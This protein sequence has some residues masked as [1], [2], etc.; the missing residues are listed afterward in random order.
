MGD[1]TGE[2]L[3]EKYK[4]TGLLGRGGM[5]AVYQGTHLR[6]GRKV[7]VK[8]LD[9]RFLANRSIVQRFGREARSASSIQHP[10]IVEV[11]DLDQLP[12]GAPFLVME[13]LD[14]ETL[15]SFIERKQRLSQSQAV[16]IF[17]QL[18]EA[19]EAAHERGI[20]HRD[21]KPDNIFLLPPSH[22]GKR[23]VKILD[24]GISQKADEVRSH[25]T[26]TGAVLGTPHYMSPEQALGESA[27]DACADVYAAAVVLYECVVGEVPYDAPN[28][29]ALLQAILRA[30]PVRPRDRGAKIEPAF[31]A[32]LLAGMAKEKS[33]R[34]QT[35]AAWRTML[36]DA[37]S[38]A[39][40]RDPRP[41]REETP[42]PF[43][44][45]SLPVA[46][47]PPSEASATSSLLSEP[48]PVWGEFATLGKKAPSPAAVA[49]AAP[50]LPDATVGN[51]TPAERVSVPP[52]PVNSTA[53][54]ELEDF[55]FDPV[56]PALELD[57]SAL[58]VP[59]R[60][61]VGQAPA[62]RGRSYGGTLQAVNPSSTTG[63]HA[64]QAPTGS[65]PRTSP[66]GTMEAV[67][68]R[69]S[70]SSAIAA[71]AQPAPAG[72][73]DTS[74]PGGDLPLPDDEPS[75]PSAPAPAARPAQRVHDLIDR[76]MSLP[77][78]V[79]LAV[80]GAFALGLLILGI[81]L[82]VGRGDETEVPAVPPPPPNLAGPVPPSAPEEP[83]TVLVDVSGLPQDARVKLDGLP[84][85]ALP[86]RVGRGEHHV[87]VIEAPG[88]DSRRVPIA[89]LQDLRISAEMRLTR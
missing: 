41:S 47:S 48:P 17:D 2:T 6:T 50:P 29:N 3:L 43:P 72:V 64:A 73:E 45:P 44:Q 58:P 60:G 31:E 34:P 74:L 88:Y 21:L 49:P 1:L 54:K 82:A 70:S 28:Y 87:L 67:A 36:L 25:L 5:G 52:P 20:V 59:G 57:D 79:H 23:A 8:V 66:S 86:L 18:L 22:S 11:L 75:P 15:G 7:A 38:G 26:Q 27:L 62:V 69:R 56:G 77:R 81:R 65:G 63:T 10:G 14:G 24:F 71:V 30:S 85:G 9:D 68:P 80:A 4:I 35:A 89:P 42:A 46:A 40:I 12:D 33:K 61:R 13:L 83:Q 32:A 53:G 84:V 39:P 78:A 76:V 37:A 16:E 55:G 19:L 51:P